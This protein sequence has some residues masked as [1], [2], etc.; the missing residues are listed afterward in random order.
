MLKDSK[1]I[2]EKDDIT[3]GAIT[4]SLG[5]IT[6]AAATIAVVAIANAPLIIFLE[7]NMKAK[8]HITLKAE[9]LDPQGNAI[10]QSLDNLN[11]LPLPMF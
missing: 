9:V 10:K 11:I 6:V 5:V 1:I 7:K 4:I 8:I 2:K 3:F